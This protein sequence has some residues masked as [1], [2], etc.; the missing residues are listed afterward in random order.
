LQPPLH[1]PEQGL[2]AAIEIIAQGASWI[3]NNLSKLQAAIS[4]ARGAST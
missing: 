4:F 1:G 3:S 2:R